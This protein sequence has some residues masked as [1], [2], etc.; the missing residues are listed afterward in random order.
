MMRIQ[1]LLSVVMTVQY[2]SDQK[3]KEI[4]DAY[5]SMP[6]AFYSSVILS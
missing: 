2:P 6:P 4:M 3:R 5:F 1:I